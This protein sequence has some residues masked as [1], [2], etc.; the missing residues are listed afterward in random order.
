MDQPCKNM[1]KLLIG[2]LVSLG[3][4]ILPSVIYAADLDIVCY[5][6]Q[7]PVIT[8][9]T[10]PLFQ[11]SGFLPGETATRT[12]SVLNTDSNNPCTISLQGSGTS[13]KLTDS[14]TLAIDSLYSNT[15]SNFVKGD[16]IQIA[17][18][19]PN[20]SVQHTITMYFDSDAGNDL[21]NLNTSFDIKV[22][23]QWGSEQGNVLSATDTNDNDGTG[24]GE[25]I[26]NPIDGTPEVLGTETNN[27][28]CTIRTL[29]WI[30]AL[31]QLVV[32]LFVLLFNKSFFKNSYIKLVI[33]IALGIVAYFVIKKIGCDCYLLNLCK[34]VWIANLLLGTTPLPKAIL[35]FIKR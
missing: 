31:I 30:P 8:Q 34:Y 29:W 11:L 4:F 18:L 26:K 28:E 13:N 24:G 9:N 7:K 20:Q 14:I 35:R 19:Q 17:N 2:I 1:K 5:E 32:T 10:T 16:N 25:E 22:N 6:N 21:T 33:T 23:S 15:L 3:I 12:V 27:T